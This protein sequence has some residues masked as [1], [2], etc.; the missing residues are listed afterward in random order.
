MNP[1]E[2]FTDAQIERWNEIIDQVSMRVAVESIEKYVVEWCRWQAAEKWLR[3]NGAVMTVR[4]SKGV[5]K[6]RI[7]AP[8]LK[9]SRESSKLVIELAGMLGLKK[10]VG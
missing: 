6:N 2:Y 10:V 9:I 1:P 3:E 4:D 8:E 5:V 7:P